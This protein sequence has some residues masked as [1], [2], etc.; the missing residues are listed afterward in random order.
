MHTQSIEPRGPRSRGLTQDEFEA[1]MDALLA[2]PEPPADDV[3]ESFY[4]AHWLP[5]LR[6]CQADARHLQTAE[7]VAS[8]AF[9]DLWRSWLRHQLR[10]YS[11]RSLSAWLYAAAR[12][13]LRHSWARRRRES[14]LDAEGVAA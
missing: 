3:F 5:L 1:A 12:R 13:G 10:D 11:D 6:F 8:A 4:I 2:L 9:C 7:D 14:P